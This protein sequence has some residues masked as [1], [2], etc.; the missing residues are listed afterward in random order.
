MKAPEPAKLYGL[1]AEFSDPSELVAAARQAH[2]AGYRHLDGYTPFPIEEL[3]EA[4][5]MHRNLPRRSFSPAVSPGCS[6]VSG[7]STGRR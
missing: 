3:S 2:E 6:P 7:C 1:M 4:L 5:G